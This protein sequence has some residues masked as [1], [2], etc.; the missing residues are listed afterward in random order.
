MKK[1][2]LVLTLAIAMLVPHT[3]VTQEEQPQAP[4]YENMGDRLLTEFLIFH[5]NYTPQILSNRC[6][7]DPTWTAVK[8]FKYGDKILYLVKIS[9]GMIS[10][11]Y[12]ADSIQPIGVTFVP[13]YQ[14]FVGYGAEESMERLLAT[15]KLQFKADPESVQGNRIVMFLTKDIA[16][17]IIM[18]PDGSYAVTTGFRKYLNI[19]EP[20]EA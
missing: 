6:A 16:A 15:I 14:P 12:P 19:P 3:A 13:D 5:N 7:A 8:R 18:A 4:V 9:N 20:E 17:V 11:A 1:I 2:M 10:F